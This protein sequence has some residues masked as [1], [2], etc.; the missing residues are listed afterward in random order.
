MKHISIQ[1]PKTEAVAIERVTIGSSVGRLSALVLRSSPWRSDQ[2]PLVVLHGI[3]RNAEELADHFLPEVMRTG[4]TIVVPHFDAK[5]WPK[6]QRPELRQRADIALAALLEHLGRTDP[7]FNKGVQ[8]FGHSGGAQLAHRF[9]MLFPH[10]VVRLGLV[11]A[12]WYCLPN[13][14]MA[15]P[16]GLGDPAKAAAAIWVQRKKAGL[17]KY[18]ALPIDIYV[19]SEDTQRDETVRQTPELD[20]IQGTT[21]IA[22]AEAYAAALKDAAVRLGITPKVTFRVLPGVTHDVSLALGQAGLAREISD[23]TLR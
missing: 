21:R 5:R 8:I 14:D 16:C 23:Q 22:R 9:A 1:M 10:K 6:F 20:A 3:S 4:R 17:H 18:L 2:A 7:S 19:G 15:F 12:G 13:D 11:A